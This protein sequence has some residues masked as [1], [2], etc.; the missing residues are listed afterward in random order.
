MSHLEC[1][2]DNGIAAMARAGVHAQLL[3]TTA[4]LLR[5]PIPPTRKLI[6]RGVPVALASDF[7]PNAH[8]YDMCTAMN[9]GCVL[10]KMTMPEALVAATINAASCIDVADECGSLEI[11][12]RGDCIILDAPTWEHIVYDMRP[13]IVEVFKDGV[14]VT[15][16]PSSARVDDSRAKVN[17]SNPSN[18]MTLSM[19]HTTTSDLSKPAVG[20]P[21]DDLPPAISSKDT[22]PASSFDAHFHQMPHAP[23]RPVELHENLVE[24]ALKNA[25]RYF[26]KRFHEELTADFLKELRTFRHIYMHRLMPRDESG[27]YMMAAQPIERYNAKSTQAAALMHMIQNNLDPSVAQFPAELITYGS[28]GSAFSNWAQYHETMRLLSEMEDDQ[29]LVLY[30]GHPMGLFPSHK[31]APR[32][33]V[34]N[35]MVVPNYSSRENYEEMFLSGVSS[36]GQMTAGSFCYI[37]PQGIV[38]GTVLTLLNAG[39]KYLGMNSL[40]GKVFVTAGEY[41]S[42][43]NCS[44]PSPFG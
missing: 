22:M 5:L 21:I 11:G 9:L 18:P 17:L 25:L 39:R 7:N 31:D 24:K 35:G 41:V 36:Y 30:S 33:V 28:N 19:S 12:K 10:F 23:R 1:L 4:Y 27:R 20:I 40:K 44:K 14:S 16:T 37:G 13:K 3:P 2:N 34:T 32:L 8:C 38:H 6:E 29:T 42:S 43:R 15:D 26:P